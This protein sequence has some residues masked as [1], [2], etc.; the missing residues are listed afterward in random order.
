MERSQD[1]AALERRF[2]HGS[3]EP[4]S[5]ARKQVIHLL[6]PGA[7]ERQFHLLSLGAAERQ[8]QGFH[9]RYALAGLVGLPDGA[10]ES[11]HRACSLGQHLS[12]TSLCAAVLSLEFRPSQE[13]LYRT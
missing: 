8:F 7:A 9:S 11:S 2:R 5:S 4:P 6:P 13:C 1:V 12:A 3:L 10:L